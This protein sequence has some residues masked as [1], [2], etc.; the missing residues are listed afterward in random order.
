MYDNSVRVSRAVELW[1]EERLRWGIIP[2]ATTTEEVLSLEGLRLLPLLSVEDRRSTLS[3]EDL[4]QLSEEDLRQLPLLSD[5]DRPSLFSL[6][7]LLPC[8]LSEEDASEWRRVASEELRDIGAVRSM[9]LEFWRPSGWVELAGSGWE[10]SS[11]QD[12]G[13]ESTSRNNCKD[14]PGVTSRCST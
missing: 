9:N 8:P 7:D 4:L 1:T 11:T 6:D 2:E 12:R 14:S 10:E 3:S 5:E 13:S